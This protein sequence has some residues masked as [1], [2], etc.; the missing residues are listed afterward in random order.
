MPNVGITLI[1]NLLYIPNLYKNLFSVSAIDNENPECKTD[2]YG[3]FN[4][5]I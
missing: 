1:E 4:G 3:E 5:G 2:I